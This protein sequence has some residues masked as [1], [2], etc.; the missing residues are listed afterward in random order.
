[1]GPVAIREE[2]RANQKICLGGHR[3]RCPIVCCCLTDR[4][5]TAPLSGTFVLVV[6]HFRLPELDLV[7]VWVHDPRKL[8]VLVRFGSLDDLHTPRTQLLQQLTEVVDSV[9]DHEGGF[10]SAEPLAV[11]L[12]DM[13]YSKGLDPRHF[14]WPL[15]VSSCA[16]AHN[17]PLSLGRSP[18]GSFK[19]LLGR[20]FPSLCRQPRRLPGHQ[21]PTAS[22]APVHSEIPNAKRVGLAARFEPHRRA[23]RYNCARAD[24]PDLARLRRDRGVP[25]GS[26]PQTL[27]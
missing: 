9:V 25:T 22:A 19:G 1:M 21:L 24:D 16:P 8:A 23:A 11:F 26:V 17:T 10:A 2:E 13:P 3:V 18:P 6:P 12:R 27:Q 20:T 14:V 15:N 5:S 4:A 7:V